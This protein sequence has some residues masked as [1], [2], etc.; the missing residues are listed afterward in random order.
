MAFKMVNMVTLMPTRNQ[1]HHLI[2]IN[3]RGPL[4]TNHPDIFSKR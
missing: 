4:L 1:Y 2:I 3:E